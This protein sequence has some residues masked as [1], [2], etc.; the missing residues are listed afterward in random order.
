M[1]ISLGLLKA[2]GF[3]AGIAATL[4]YGFNLVSATAANWTIFKTLP[5]E[6]K[7]QTNL[8]KEILKEVSKR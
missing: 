5:E 8:L 6:L 2:T 7:K 1:E 4:Y 3:A